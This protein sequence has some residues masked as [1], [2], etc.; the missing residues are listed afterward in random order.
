MHNIFT[1]ESRERTPL[2]KYTSSIKAK[3]DSTVDNTVVEAFFRQIMCENMVLYQFLLYTLSLYISGEQKED[4]RTFL[5]CHGDG[6][7]GKSTMLE[8]FENL[9]GDY[10]HTA[11]TA[12][13]QATSTGDAN[14]HTAHLNVLAGKRLSVLSEPVKGKKLDVTQIKRLT[15]SDKFYKRGM[16]EEAS[17]LTITSH[18]IIVT[19]KLPEIDDPDK[20]F[21][22]RL[23]VLPFDA[24]FVKDPTEP[25]E[26][27]AVGDIAKTLTLMHYLLCYVLMVINTTKIRG[28]MLSLIG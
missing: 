26:Y 6:K 23:L 22:D 12:V 24:K 13:M 28:C 7:N 4:A 16:Y 2:D 27:Q 10:M 17:L 5:I 8:L 15:G 3:Y 19:N 11:A 21:L 18:F 1:G 14:T 25:N 20:A 9:L